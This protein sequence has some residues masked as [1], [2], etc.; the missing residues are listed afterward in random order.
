MPLADDDLRTRLDALPAP[1]VDTDADLGNVRARATRRRRRRGLA[2]VGAVLAVVLAGVAVVAR[3]N[4]EGRARSI[5]AEPSPTTT[6]P[7]PR[8][9]PKIPASAIARF[10]LPEGVGGS[11]AI[12]GGSIW[13]GGSGADDDTCPG[14]FCGSVSRIDPKSG[15]VVARIAV[16]K[17]PRSL[18]HA[19]GA[20][21]AVTEL[22]NNTPATMVKIDAATNGVVAQHDIEGSVVVGETTKVGVTAGAGGIW[23]FYGWWLV[24]LDPATG[25]IVATAKLPQSPD[26]HDGILANDDGVWIVENGSRVWRI[27][28]E[29]LAVSELAPLPPGYVQSAALE[30]D[31]IWLTETHNAVAG[32]REPVPELIAVDTRTGRVTYTGTA[33]AFVAAGEGRVWVQTL[34]SLVEI[35]PRTRKGLRQA[36]FGRDESSSATA[37]VDRRTIW[38]VRGE[39]L[40]RIHA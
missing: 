24:K 30:G 2:L 7:L 34:D 32:S 1:D 33:T 18:V 16:E 39:R 11:V 27:D 6:T 28:P 36:P 20:L 13:V 14:A 15:R 35:D 25:D 12:G 26:L 19:D 8:N 21:W 10:T 9:V 23:A 29:T 40:I 31:T 17:H 37:V 22:P 3:T 38:L 4:D 5:V